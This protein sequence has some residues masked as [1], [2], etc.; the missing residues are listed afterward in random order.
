MSIRD[1]ATSVEVAAKVE[2]L[3]EQLLSHTVVMRRYYQLEQ[4]G[5][6]P[7]SYATESISDTVQVPQAVFSGVYGVGL[8]FDA[9]FERPLVL[10][11]QKLAST[12][13]QDLR[14]LPDLRQLI[15][16]LSGTPAPLDTVA[17][18]ITPPTP[19]FGPG[20]EISCHIKQGTLGAL[21]SSGD[22]S[23]AIL[24]AGHV[25]TSGLRA[26]HNGV[27][28]GSITFVADPALAPP[29][30]A[31]ADV[32]VVAIDRSSL[33]AVG[34][35]CP[36]GGTGTAR[37][38]SDIVCYGIR[39]PLAGQIHA[40]AKWVFSPSMAGMWADVYLTTNQMSAPGDSGAPVLLSAT[41]K[42]IGHVV[43]ASVG[44]TTYIQAIDIQLSVSGCKLR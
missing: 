29:D 21:V 16:E 22:S 36:I 9:G 7:V 11:N 41:D 37:G 32:A 6:P 18:G 39:G 33:G 13:P 40:L 20:D 5:P 3:A 8:T 24:T 26:R 19:Q 12:A 27:E 4:T 25:C 17:V 28:F 10:C 38:G 23:D 2:L 35:T 44:V 30:T 31:S 34:P 1:F 42:I 43:G 15:E 14:N